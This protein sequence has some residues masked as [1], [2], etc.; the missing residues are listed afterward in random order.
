MLLK[1]HI[2]ICLLL[3]L[4]SQVGF[5]QQKLRF[6]THYRVSTNDCNLP[7]KV[8]EK[9]SDPKYVY[10]LAEQHISSSGDTIFV[11]KIDSLI[12]DP[13]FKKLNEDIFQKYSTIKVSIKQKGS[14]LLLY[15]FPFSDD[16]TVINKYLQDNQLVLKIKDKY[17]I[18]LPF[19]GWEV[20]ALTIPVKVYLSSRADNLKNN[21]IFDES[22]NIKLS[23]IWGNEY[24]YKNEGDKDG[25]SFQ[26]YFN[27]SLFIGFSKTEISNSNT[28]IDIGDDS[29]TVASL[30][31]GFGVGYNVRG[32][33]LSVL[34]GLD[35]PL[36]DQ[37]D[38]WNFRNQPWIGFGLGID[39]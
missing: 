26:N 8:K 17:R 20:G 35:T 1:K 2:I 11:R 6:K 19:R 37:A 13:S 21:F 38:E 14:E 30:N 33:G 39:L 36:S 27:A 24:F 4:Y 28:Q 32:I 23:R 10:K 18:G 5:G 29:F 31:Y 25:K 16:D 7:L 15:P 22:I 3:V 12:Y 34:L 9:L